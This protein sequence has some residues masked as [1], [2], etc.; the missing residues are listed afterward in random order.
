ML[1]RFLI[2]V[3]G[4]AA[5]TPGLKAE[6]STPQVLHELKEFYETLGKRFKNLEEKIADP[7][8]EV[9]IATRFLQTTFSHFREQELKGNLIFKTL[10]LAPELKAKL[11]SL[12]NKK[13]KNNSSDKVS[14]EKESQEGFTFENL[15]LIMKESLS[16]LKDEEKVQ[17]A[18]LLLVDLEK[19]TKNFFANDKSIASL[20]KRYQKDPFLEKTKS[21]KNKG[22]AL[23]EEI[24]RLGLSNPESLDTLFNPLR[25]QIYISEKS[26]LKPLLQSQVPKFSEIASILRSLTPANNSSVS[27][28]MA[29][30][31]YAGHRFSGGAV[32]PGGRFN[33]S[34]GASV[35]PGVFGPVPQAQDTEELKKC[36]E[37]IRQKRF[38]VE[39]Q[40]P[41]SLCASTPISKDPQKSLDSFRKGL[42]KTCQVNLATALHCVEG[43]GNLAG[44]TI[45]TNMGN[46]A[47]P[48][49]ILQVGTADELRGPSVHNGNPDL[50][51]LN[52]EVPC[53]SASLLN[54]ARVPTPEEIKEMAQKDSLGIVMQQ[55][56]IINASQGGN[57][58]ATIA[59]T[60]RFEQTENGF[61]GNYIRFNS[62]SSFNGSSLLGSGLALDSS[63]IKSGDS[64]GAALS[65]KF[66]EDQKIKDVLYM[67]AISHV[68][69]RGDR[70]EGKQGGIASGQSLL[71]LSQQIYGRSQ[72][73][74][75]RFAD[76]NRTENRN[77]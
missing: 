19:K 22:L 77:H 41:G 2:L 10:D 69:V 68:L 29:L 25:K 49:K 15:D 60:G 24:I 44:T 47:T 67:G 55:N 72:Q 59:A 73:G 62:N 35:S 50:I 1:Y 71:N 4:L 65:C 52:V 16:Q 43:K 42:Q 3:F 57:N 74:T 27:N 6:T 40:L 7:K 5:I 8:Q 9:S 39:L 48:T 20:I 54:V 70:E 66:D 33:F 30:T 23:L 36:T 17:L 26:K 51:V 38:N 11:V 13:N 58:R 56:S 28:G 21:S 32:A 34:G 18:A 45:V 14:A 37:E 61:L 31:P 64:G 46:R 53:D 75:A 76:S 12:L 63:R